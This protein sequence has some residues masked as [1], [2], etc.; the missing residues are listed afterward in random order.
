MDKRT[1]AHREHSF[2][3][4]E[5]MIKITLA[6]REHKLFTNYHQVCDYINTIERKKALEPEAKI[7][8]FIRRRY[9]TLYSLYYRN[10]SQK[11]LLTPKER[12]AVEKE[13]GLVEIIKGNRE[14]IIQFLFRSH[15]D[16]EPLKKDWCKEYCKAYG[17]I[18]SEFELVMNN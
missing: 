7:W 14:D 17:L 12:E 3:E 15:L 18:H 13:M 6:N 1:I 5:T 8:S 16:L 2:Q 10:P 11:D 9:E 4:Q